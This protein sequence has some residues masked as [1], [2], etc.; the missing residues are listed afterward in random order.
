MANTFIRKISR[1]IGTAAV[2]VGD[3]TVA[4]DT[5]TVLIGLTVS[6]T[7][8][9]T[10]KVNIYVDDGSSQYYLIKG[11]DIASGGALIPVGGDHKMIMIP[12]ESLKVSSDTANSIDAI[13]SVL[14]ISAA[15]AAPLGLEGD[16]ASLSGTE[17]LS[18]GTG[19]EDLQA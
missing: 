11:A 3:Y 12:G 9:S 5:Q 16:L 1:N 4:S 6:N 2:T 19:T 7:Y 15:A 14:E 10:V 8:T 18:T 13:L 17:D